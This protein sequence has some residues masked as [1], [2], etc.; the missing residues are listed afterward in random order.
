M[1]HRGLGVSLP[2]QQLTY[3]GE[4]VFYTYLTS[5]PNLDLFYRV[6]ILTFLVGICSR[7]RVCLPMVAIYW[8]VAHWRL[9]V[10]PYEPA[11]LGQVV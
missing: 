7:N 11:T 2:H 8:F 1:C 6:L 9:P 3:Q 10:R 5:L 4:T